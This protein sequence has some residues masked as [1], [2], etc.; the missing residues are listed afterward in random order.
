MKIAVYAG[1]PLLICATAF[2]SL[3]LSNKDIVLSFVLILIQLGLLAMQWLIDYKYGD[4]RRA[5]TEVTFENALENL[6]KLG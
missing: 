4:A 1:I 3:V 6:A 2:F 5:I